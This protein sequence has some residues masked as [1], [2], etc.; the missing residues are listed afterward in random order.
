MIVYVSTCILQLSKERGREY[1]GGVIP[2]H[3][4]GLEAAERV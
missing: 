3:L 1:W 4:R 2:V